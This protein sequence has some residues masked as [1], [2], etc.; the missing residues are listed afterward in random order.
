M[1]EFYTKISQMSNEALDKELRRLVG[2]KDDSID[3]EVEEL[4]PDKEE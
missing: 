3:A 1:A 2:K 4:E